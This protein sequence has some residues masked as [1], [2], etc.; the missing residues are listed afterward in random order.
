MPRAMND[1]DRMQGRMVLCQWATYYP[2][3]VK[4]MPL[5]A[6]DSLSPMT[7]QDAYLSVEAW[8]SVQPFSEAG[9]KDHLRGWFRNTKGAITKSAAEPDKFRDLRLELESI[10]AQACYEI[11]EG[12]LETKETYQAGPSSE[13]WAS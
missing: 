5:G 13:R 7:R 4:P 12:I 11:A 8:L 9:L 1:V 2:K 3:G 6:Y 10:A